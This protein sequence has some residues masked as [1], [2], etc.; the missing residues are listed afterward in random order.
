MV[1]GDEG[2]GDVFADIDDE[3]AG[4]RPVVAVEA[5]RRADP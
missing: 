3:R 1:G 4:G 2:A 5:Q